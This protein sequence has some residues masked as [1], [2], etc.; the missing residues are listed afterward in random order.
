MKRLQVSQFF[1]FL[2][3]GIS[4]LLFY[5]YLGEFEGSG[6]LANGNLISV[7][8]GFIG[9]TKVFLALAKI[10][11]EKSASK[12]SEKQFSAILALWVFL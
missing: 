4:C 3:C 2:L 11:F 6:V 8:F 1:C 7:I 5:K 12:R 10:S 9:L